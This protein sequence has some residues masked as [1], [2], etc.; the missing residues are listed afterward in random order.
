MQLPVRTEKLTVGEM[1]VVVMAPEAAGQYPVVIGLHGLGGNKET[2]IPLL[3]PLAAMGYIDRRAGCPLPRRAVRP[4]V[5]AVRA[6][7]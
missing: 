7:G 5:G 1:P 4:R 3:Q 2:M 6:D